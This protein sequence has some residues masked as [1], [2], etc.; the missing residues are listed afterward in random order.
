MVSKIHKKKQNLRLSSLVEF[1]P[2][3]N[4][5]L[6]ITKITLIL[7]DPLL[8]VYTSGAKVFNLYFIFNDFQE[9]CNFF[10]RDT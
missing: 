10:Y 5:N 2:K 7:K 6:Q 9:E 1:S 3:D 8:Y 4:L